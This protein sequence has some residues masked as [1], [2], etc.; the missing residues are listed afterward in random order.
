MTLSS[1]KLMVIGAAG[2]R[3]VE[4]LGDA[5][6]RD[7]LLRAEQHGAAD[8]HLP[9][10]PGAPD[11]DRVGRLDVALDRGLP[12]GRE[13]VAEKQHLLVGKAAF[14]TL[15]WVLSANGTRTY[16]AWPPA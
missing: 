9:D 13:D 5:V 3:H 12:A 6:D 1:S 4:A 8:R 15:M 7:H 11:R 16:S 2:A 14:G 10:G